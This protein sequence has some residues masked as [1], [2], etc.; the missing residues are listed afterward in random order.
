MLQIFCLVFGCH[1]ETTKGSLF[2]MDDTATPADSQRLR[3][4]DQ[5]GIVV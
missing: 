5:I 2:M 4:T 1:L 3:T